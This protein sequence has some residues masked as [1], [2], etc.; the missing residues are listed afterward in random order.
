M[1][2][3][4]FI[5]WTLLHSCAAIVG[6]TSYIG[7]GTGI[8]P[9]ATFG[10]DN[11][12]TLTFRPRI[13][14]IDSNTTFFFC[15]DKEH[16]NINTQKDIAKLCSGTPF[17]TLSN[18]PL[19]EDTINYVVE[20]KNLYHLLLLKCSEGLVDVSVEYELLNPNHE[21]LEVGEI[22]LPSIYM[23]LVIV[24]FIVLVVGGVDWMRHKSFVVIFHTLLGMAPLCM[25]N[26]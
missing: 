6:H 16:G 18:V 17:C 15:T 20:S 1:L 21:Q 10:Y 22:P 8:I 25:Y 11:G 9:I 13:D 7:P 4:L 26:N 12:G 24:W 3:Y 19:D 2:G 5:F 14:D 23:A